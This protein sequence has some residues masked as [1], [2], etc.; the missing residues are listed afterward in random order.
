MP[1]LRGSEIAGHSFFGGKKKESTKKPVGKFKGT[2]RVVENRD[3]THPL[4]AMDILKPKA[5]VIRWVGS[6]LW[7]LCPLRPRCHP[8]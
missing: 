3:D 2:I 7:R 6:A 5:Y 1:C 4:L 8:G